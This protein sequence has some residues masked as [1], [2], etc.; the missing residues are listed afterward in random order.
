MLG[1]MA[2]RILRNILSDIEKKFSKHVEVYE[3]NNLLRF[4]V[5]NAEVIDKMSVRLLAME[6][7]RL[8]GVEIRVYE[9]SLF[10]DLEF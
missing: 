4:Y 9:I 7:L 2:R 3:Y 10:I 1:F 5:D 8:N 6:D